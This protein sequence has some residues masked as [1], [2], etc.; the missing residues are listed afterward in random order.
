[1]IQ[2]SN[3]RALIQ[4]GYDH[5]A[6]AFINANITAIQAVFTRDFEWRLPDGGS[7]DRAATEAAIRKQ[8]DATVRVHEMSISIEQLA[9]SGGRA[10][11]CTKERL[12][13]TVRGEDGRLERQTTRETYR[14]VWVRTRKG[15]RFRLADLL[16]SETTRE[17]IS[18]MFP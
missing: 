2:E 11:A 13:A 4:A 3:V 8:M 1:M 17:A 5:Y 12:V 7:L 6:A 9:V 16:S 18:A 10:T 15:W 14:D